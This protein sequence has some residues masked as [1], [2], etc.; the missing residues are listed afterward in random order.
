MYTK[1][2]Q[3][4]T[5][6]KFQFSEHIWISILVLILL[7]LAFN[8]L[9]TIITLILT[10]RQQ[11]MSPITLTIS[12]F[13]CYALS[14]FLIVPR[15]LHLPEGKKSLSEYLKDIRLRSSQ[16]IL[17]ILALGLSC[18]FIYMLSQLLSSLIYGQY[19]F[20][21]SLALPPNSWGLLQNIPF[22]LAEEIT[23]R[24]LILTLLLKKYSEK[25]SILISAA[26]MGSYHILGL[27]S[28]DSSFS[29]ENLVW[30]SGQ[31]VWAFII[32]LFY[33]YTFIK[34]KSLLPCIMVHY[35]SNTL[36]NLWVVLPA[37]PVELHVLYAIIFQEG[38]I[39]TALS[40]LWVRFYTS[41]WFPVSESG[42]DLNT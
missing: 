9:A 17:H 16:P 5:K 12:L 21:I 37:A 31:V 28:L 24:G 15:L 18:Y 1:Q 19:S 33:G 4:S 3:N 14:L 27:F 40:I 35:L 39:P 29:Y 26:I 36:I 7:Y 34:A 42:N 30:Y 22:V 38:I 13:V 11:Q 25:Q 32:G 41:R 8:I 10:P 2:N 20:D 6:R 23:V